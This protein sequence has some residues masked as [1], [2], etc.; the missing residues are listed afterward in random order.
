MNTF[1]KKL[2]P[3]KGLCVMNTLMKKL[4]PRKGLC[5]MNTLMKKLCVGS[6]AVLLLSAPVHASTISVEDWSGDPSSNG[7]VDWS[8]GSAA[9]THARNFAKNTAVDVTFVPTDGYGLTGS[10]TFYGMSNPASFSGPGG[11]GSLAPAASSSETGGADTIDGVGGAITRGFRAGGTSSPTL[12]LTGLTANT[13]YE[14]VLYQADYQ[15]GTTSTLSFVNSGA[16]SSGNAT[17]NDVDRGN[18]KISIA[19]TTGTNTE[20]SL[21]STGGNF[22]WFNFSNETIPEPATLI[23]LA[24]GLPALLKR[25]RSRG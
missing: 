12:T 11:S 24:A 25:R 14:L 23:L 10:F 13:E 18:T 4:E 2:E 9:F 19:Y 16:G 5:V 1:M 22:N 7:Q 17:E 6:L 8:A 3:R 20:V 21:T 15:T